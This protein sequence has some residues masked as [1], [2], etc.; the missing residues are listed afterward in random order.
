MLDDD[1]VA[2]IC[3]QHKFNSK[4]IDEALARYQTDSKYKGLEM[5][6]WQVT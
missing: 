1:D 3:H 6:E 5:Y 4:K 2:R